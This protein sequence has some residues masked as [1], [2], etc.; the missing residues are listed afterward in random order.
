MSIVQQRFFRSHLGPVS[1]AFAA[2]V[3]ITSAPRVSAN[4]KPTE[5]PAKVIA[6]LAL[7]DAPGNEMLLQS[8]GDKQYSIRPESVQAGFHGDRCHQARAAHP[9][10]S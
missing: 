10:Q 8:K 9:R 1:I 6:H 7:K 3:V 2:A 5:V 4:N